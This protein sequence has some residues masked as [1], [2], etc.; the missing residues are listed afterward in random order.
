MQELVLI[1]SV[2]EHGAGC[3]GSQDIILR[4]LLY[5]CETWSFTCTEERK[6]SV[7][8]AK[9]IWSKKEDKTARWQV[10]DLYSSPSIIWIIK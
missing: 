4:V 1:N 9:I 5:G 7:F 3:E 2:T 10:R 8:E 6:V